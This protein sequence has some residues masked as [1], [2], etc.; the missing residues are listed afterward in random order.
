MRFQKILAFF[1]LSWLIKTLLD[2]PKIDS[3]ERLTLLAAINCKNCLIPH[4]I[5]NFNRINKFDKEIKYV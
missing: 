1:H 4:P 5:P 2:F 3:Y